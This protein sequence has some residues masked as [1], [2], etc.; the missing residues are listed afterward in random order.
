MNP[1]STILA[2]QRFPGSA[3]RLTSAAALLFTASAACAL[4][5]GRPATEAVLGEALD[6][7]IPVRLDA[8]EDLQDNCLTAEVYFG[9]NKQMQGTV[10]VRVEGAG[11]AGGN[12]RT[13][14][15]STTRRVDEPFV[16][17]DRKSVV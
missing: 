14:R 7:A 15:V 4:G 6:L 16:T 12:Q 3:L 11:V 1:H 10:Q 9:E 2:C 13:V 8:G 17:L 5:F